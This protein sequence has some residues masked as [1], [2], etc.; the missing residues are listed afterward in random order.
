MYQILK[1]QLAR[2]LKRGKKKHFRE[3]WF[4]V[5][6]GHSLSEAWF[7]YPLPSG[8]PCLWRR[9]RER[10][11]KGSFLPLAPVTIQNYFLTRLSLKAEINSSWPKWHNSSLNSLSLSAIFRRCYFS[12]VLCG[13]QK[14]SSPCVCRKNLNNKRVFFFTLHMILIL[15]QWG[16]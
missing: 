10:V 15:S 14:M 8:Y 2:H 3:P 5:V 13:Y 6:G 12:C 9:S 1:D 7:S 4:A 16:P 11:C